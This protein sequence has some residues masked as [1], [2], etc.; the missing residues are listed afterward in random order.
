LNY[1]IYQYEIYY[2]VQLFVSL[3]YGVG[4][5]WVFVILCLV[6]KK[7]KKSENNN[8]LF[9]MF[10]KNFEVLKNHQVSV[11]CFIF[12]WS[13]L[14]PKT[15]KIIGMPAYHLRILNFTII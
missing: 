9:K 2:I 11:V 13:L 14:V 15:L 4:L 10:F 1:N 8:F 6:T 12:I 3:I 5:Y 7:Y